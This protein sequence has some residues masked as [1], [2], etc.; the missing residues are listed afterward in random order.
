MLQNLSSDMKLQED[1]L[2]QVCT[3]CQLS[4]LPC[5][6]LCPEFIFTPIYKKDDEQYVQI[7]KLL[8]K[9]ILQ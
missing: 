4:H 2:D 5:L 1:S 8:K 3:C 7:L 6:H 9:K